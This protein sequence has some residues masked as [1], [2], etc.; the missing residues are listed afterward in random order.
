MKRKKPMKSEW[1][2]IRTTK[3]AKNKLEAYA[4]MHGVSVTH[5]LTEYI[6][7]LP[8]LPKDAAKPSDELAA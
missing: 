8:N 4:D 3:H 1:I 2:R 5:V 6:R 7:R